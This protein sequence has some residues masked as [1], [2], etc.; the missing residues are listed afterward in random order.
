MVMFLWMNPSPPSCAMA[1]AV[2]ASVTVSMA[3]LT[4]GS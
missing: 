1:M 3:A 4:S 2:R